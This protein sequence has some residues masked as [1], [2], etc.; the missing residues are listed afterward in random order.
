[1]SKK[2]D[3][4]HLKLRGNIWWYQR[5]V[6]KHLINHYPDQTFI[7]IS[8]ET[9][10][11]RL[12]RQKR[13]VLNGELEKKALTTSPNNEG[14]KF[15]E[16]VR[17][18]ERSRKHYPKEWDLGIYPE[19]LLEQGRT[20]ELEAYMTVNG[21]R[22]F[23]DKYKMR[24]TEAYTL[25]QADWGKGKT[26]ETL[27]KTEASISDFNKYCFKH[28]DWVEDPDIALDDISKKMV[29]QYIK[30]LE[31]TYKKTTVQ[32]KI[33]RLKVVWQ[34]AETIEEVSG[35]NPFT[36]HKYSSEESRLTDKREPFN[37][38]E[39][40]KIRAHSWERPVYNLLVEL[41]IFTGCRISE[42]CNLRKRDVIKDGSII[43]INI[44]K[45][46]TKAATR[47]VPLPDAL[48]L[49]LLSHI[50]NKSDADLVIGVSGKTASRTF[51]NYKVKHITESKLKGFHSFRHMYIT[52][53][54]QA[55]TP[56]D[57]TAQLAGHER[58]KTM[59]YGYYSR[60]HQLKTLK[61]AV[62]KALPYIIQP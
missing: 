59:S 23:S 6:P 24:L 61:A 1:M 16:L 17:D 21:A 46:K 36:G 12:A 5:R 60:G 49:R 34:F 38:E 37:K 27:Q 32:A 8:L 10:D 52:A 39:L 57:I 3:T 51:S 35:A 62:E 9:G 13:D 58:G 29:Y 18:M 20:L 56:E 11:I 48:G 26:A 22:D 33:S 14:Q 30:H 47:T 45:G 41:G 19:R 25:W 7:Q 42:L 50:E 44:E 2:T 28:F 54:D 53:L 40:A 4:K 15:R 55:Y 31:K 43:A